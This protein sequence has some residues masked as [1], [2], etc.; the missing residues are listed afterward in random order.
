MLGRNASANIEPTEI[1]QMCQQLIDLAARLHSEPSPII[2]IRSGAL[3]AFVKGRS[4]NG[5]WIRAYHTGGMEERVVDVT[6][7]GNGWLG[8]FGAALTQELANSNFDSLAQDLHFLRKAAA[9]GSVSACES[10]RVAM[11]ENHG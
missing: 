10:M 4:V 9:F 7:G 8:G 11:M 1:E 6:G 3:G 5:F 2:C